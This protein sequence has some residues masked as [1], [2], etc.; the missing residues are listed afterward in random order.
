[1][2]ENVEERVGMEY[3][4]RKVALVVQV[5]LV[6]ELIP[7]EAQAKPHTMPQL[8][9]EVEEPEGAAR[10]QMEVAEL[11]ELVAQASS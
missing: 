5:I 3:P 6:V 7:E 11:A 8:T 10:I 4:I 2:A 9:Q 1:M